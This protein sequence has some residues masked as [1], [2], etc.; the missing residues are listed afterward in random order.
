MAGSTG[1]YRS[2]AIDFVKALANRDYDAAYALTSRNYQ[3]RTTLSAMRKGFETIVPTDWGPMGEIGA[4]QTMEEWPGKQV[5]DAGWV[6]VSVGG[7]MYS[8]AVT[9]VVAREDGA[10]KVREADFGRP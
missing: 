8:E 1:D 7:D 4:G 6:Y 3:R 10:L 2:A 9:V 5:D